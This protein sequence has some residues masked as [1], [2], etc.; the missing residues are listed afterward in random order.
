LDR[1][2]LLAAR[3]RAAGERPY[4]ATA[5]YALTVVPS[6]D[7][8][9]M[10]VDRHWRCYVAPSFVDTTPVEELA[11]VWIHEVAHLLRDH[12]GR[13]ERLDNAQ[14]REPL[15]ANLAQDCEINDDLV[16][17]GMPLP[18]GHVT[19][20]QFRLPQGL[21]FEDYLRRLPPVTKITCT[22][23]CGSGAHGRPMPWD[24]DTADAPSLSPVEAE[25]IRRQTAEG[26]RQHERSRGSVPAGWKRWAEQILEPTVDWRRVLAGAVREACAWVMGALDYRY[27]RPARRSAAL[28]GVILPGLRRPLPRVAVVVDTSGSMSDDDLTAALTEIAGVLRAVG[29]GSNRVT[30]LSCDADVHTARQ[31]HTLGQV[32]LLGGGGTDMRVGIDAALTGP[33]PPTVVVVL[34]DGYTP[35][36]ERPPAARLIAGL[37]GEDPPQP[38]RWIETVRI[39]P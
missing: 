11:G 9:A 1:T 13:Y 35:W 36:P 3:L 20:D 32:E 16:A 30:V 15:L 7:V 28:T 10:A 33:E 12:H 22:S 17:D 14:Q 34:T 29:V 37:I 19:P 27:N 38:P 26:V 25:S 8:P 6:T 21:L 23:E 4:L 24:L 39:T 18:A 5:L 2:K 31:V